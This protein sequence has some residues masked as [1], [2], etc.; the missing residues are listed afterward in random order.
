MQRIKN[1]ARHIHRKV[2]FIPTRHLPVSFFRGNCPYL[3]L[4]ENSHFYKGYSAKA[5]MY[6]VNDRYTA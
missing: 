6:N 5:V 4:L 2:F 1:S 3:I